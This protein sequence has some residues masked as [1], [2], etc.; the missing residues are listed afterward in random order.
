MS[1]PIP[2]YELQRHC[3]PRERRES[4][5]PAPLVSTPRH[6]RT[7]GNPAPLVSTPRHSRT[8]GNLAQ[9]VRQTWIPAFAGMTAITIAAQELRRFLEG[10]GYV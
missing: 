4:G 8:S 3:R 10:L 5:N 1:E 7:S 6:S 2:P 9:R